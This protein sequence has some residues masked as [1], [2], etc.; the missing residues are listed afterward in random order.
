M[1]TFKVYDRTHKGRLL[2]ELRVTHSYTTHCI[3][4]HTITPVIDPVFSR[5]TPES[6]TVRTVDFMKEWTRQC[7]EESET[8]RH[9]VEE[10]ILLTNAPMG[11]LIRIREF[12][13][14]GE[15]AMVD[16]YGY[17]GGVY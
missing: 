4:M 17:G 10:A 14:E 9:I 12:K 16:R 8:R 15:D 1:P 13:P 3:R 6:G 11:D 7:T 5:K 2:G